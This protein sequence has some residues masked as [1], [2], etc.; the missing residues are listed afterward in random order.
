M[1]QSKTPPP[2]SPHW[3][4]KLAPGIIK[5]QKKLGIKNLHVDDMKTP[6]GRVHT[7]ALRGVLLHDLMAKVLQVEHPE[8]ISTYVFNDMDPMDGL[9]AYLD[10]E[11]YVQH[12]G[13]PLYQIPAPALDRSGVNFS[14][15][16][17]EEGAKYKQAKSFAEFYAFDFIDAFRRLGCEQKIV[18][19]HEL[20][21]SGQMD[22]VIKTALDNVDQMRK[23]YKEVADYDLPKNW[24][25]FQVTCEQCGKVGTTLV[26]GWDGKQVTYECQP[27]KVSWAMGCNHRGKISPF[28]GTGKLLWK[29]DWPAHWAS[30]GVNVEGAGKDHSSAGGSRDMGKAMCEQVFD[31]PNPFDIPYEW[32]LIR[33]AKM[34]SSKGVGT[35]AREFVQLFP[36]E[37][38]R[39]L[40][41][42]AHYNSVID[43][44]PRTMSIPDLFDGYDQGAR[45]FWKE[46]E[47]DQR[48][49]RAFELSQINE[50]PSAYFIPRFR[51]IALWMQHP[52]IDLVEKFTEIKGSDLSEQEIKELEDRQ[53]YAQIWVDN[54]APEEYQLTPA[55]TLPAGAQEMSAEQIEFFVKTVEL[56]SSKKNWEPQELQ[57]AI[58]VLAKAG[59]GAKQ[60]FA[61]VYLALLGKTSG[62]KSAWLL[63]ATAPTLLTTRIEQLKKQ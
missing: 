40:F 50:V 59:I 63:L 62:P 16:S 60:G 51:D 21:E 52:E 2:Q 58:Y 26:T 61:A 9:P 57:Q 5:W 39:F 31:I 38:G 23:I 24:Y 27:N 18:W 4:D 30:M 15:A 35:S 8:T 56:A 20:Y 14:Q 3:A 46:E 44:D 43:F 41:T 6:S 13:K 12:M 42:H 7:G 33:G 34:S 1:N 55:A 47:G 19:S 28:G 45:I 22:E 54:Y 36:P 25:P 48:Q 11:E 17:E 32:I 49:G 29:V 37:V 53:K 10:K